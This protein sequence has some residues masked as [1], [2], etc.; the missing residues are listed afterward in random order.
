MST[1]GNKMES[2]IIIFLEKIYYP[3]KFECNIF[4]N[5]VIFIALK[6]NNFTFLK[7]ILSDI[8]QFFLFSI[9]NLYRIS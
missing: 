8:Q 5:H 3:D 4:G 1:V 2:N 7:P 6:I 9:C